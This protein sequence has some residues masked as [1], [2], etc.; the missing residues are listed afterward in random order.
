MDAIA[1]NTTLYRTFLGLACVVLVV[2]CLSLAQKV[3]I[4]VALAMLLTFILSPAVTALQRRGLGR[5]PTVLV[6]AVLAFVLLGGIGLGMMLQLKGLAERLPQYRDNIT[7]KIAGLR[8]M[9]QDTV[10]DKVQ[11]TIHQITVELSQ[12]HGKARPE[13]EPVPV[14]LE[15]SG[16][17]TIQAAL[18]P[19]SE[20]LATAGLV[21]VL[22]IFMLIQKE[23]LRNR[24]VQL[25][26]PRNV[27]T[28]TRAL[29]E[30]ARRIS[31][32]LLA[33]LFINAVFGLA[34]GLGLAALGVEYS[35]LW[36][37]MAMALRFVPYLGTWVLAGTL[38]LFVWATSPDWQQP[39]SVVGL[40]GVLEVIAYNVLEPLLFGKSAG[41]TP[42]ALLVAILFWTWLWGPIGLIL[43]TPLTAC[44]AVL[45]K[46]VPQMEFFGVLLG[47]EPALET[48]ITYYQRLLARDQD[49]A[50][51]LVEEWLEDRPLEK[52]YDEVLV[53]ALV[54]AKRDRGRDELTVEDEEF[55]YQATR[56][57]LDD[58][59]L[60][61]QQI[62]RIATTGDVGEPERPSVLLLGCPAR[63][64]ADE[65]ALHMLRHL[66]D[67]SG[68]R[69]EVLS[70]RTL[71]GEVL[72]QMRETETPLVVIGSLPP[73][74]LSQT[75]YLCKRLR[76]QFPR[77]KIVVGRWGVDED[78][79]RVRERLLA[80]GADAVTMSLE[81]SRTQL[82]P[83]IQVLAHTTEAVEA[84]TV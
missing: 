24:L 10:L 55:I 26:G 56:D 71:A 78:F 76:A 72:A 31:R 37:F 38:L 16:F 51:D 82:M 40:F 52:V 21:G 53:P 32:Y 77:V 79:G 5:V 12:S 29:D 14:R 83:M 23:D 60:R 42:V 39:A 9:G 20:F 11:E 47:D 73:G 25:I 43:A 48:D 63:D 58:L 4:P 66:L 81:E 1:P 75:R 84:Q 54:H 46:Y 15:S 50:T 13:P 3:L 59:L 30:A 41:I 44:L 61:H 80:A 2:A 33:Q 8:G 34:L 28:T 69:V 49:E 17:D 68:A 57:L 35:L 36:G 65:L 74:G 62:R 67:G 45:G 18:G 6:V 64:E 19:V 70:A 27:I 7:Q 22:M